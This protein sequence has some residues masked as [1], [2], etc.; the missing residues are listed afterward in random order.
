MVDFRLRVSNLQD[1][2]ESE[3]VRHELV[4]GGNELLVIY[5]LFKK[6]SIS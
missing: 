6:Q 3:K 5:G 2:G 1:Q 4:G